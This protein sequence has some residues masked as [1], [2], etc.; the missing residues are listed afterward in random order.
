[1]IKS[2]IATCGVDW[3]SSGH[4]HPLMFVVRVFIQGQRVDA[5]PLDTHCPGGQRHSLAVK[6]CR[7]NV[8]LYVNEMLTCSRRCCSSCG[9][10]SCEDFLVHSDGP[11]VSEERRK[12]DMTWCIHASIGHSG[13]PGLIV[14]PDRL[15]VPLN[16]R[17]H[18]LSHWNGAISWTKPT[19]TKVFNP[20]DLSRCDTVLKTY[21]INDYN[22]WFKLL[23]F[24]YKY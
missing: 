2:C 6:T 24:W 4:Q 18:P 17:Q 23:H 8:I 21:F 1:M 16:E 12:W 15:G 19:T 13:H 22:N 9:S 7:F 14:L 20:S 5:V 10:L 11:V 3:H